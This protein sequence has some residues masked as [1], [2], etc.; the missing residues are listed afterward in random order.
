MEDL[1]EVITVAE[2]HPHHCHLLAFSSSTGTTRLCDMR[3]RALC[4]Q[5]AKLF[6]EAVDP[7]R[8]SFFSEIVSSVSDV[9]FSH[10]GRYLLTRDYLTVKVWDLNMEN[11]PVET[12]QVSHLLTHSHSV[13]VRTYESFSEH[14]KLVWLY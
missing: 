3:A 6:E 8:R 5:H 10:S 11:K 2:F 14:V 1:S 7:S 4:D 12:Y 9:K 13:S